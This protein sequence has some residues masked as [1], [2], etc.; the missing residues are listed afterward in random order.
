V[1]GDVCGK[2]PAAAAITALARYTVRAEALHA[3]KPSTVLAGL[4]EAL[5]HYYPDQF[6]TALFVVIDAFEQRVHLTV[7]SGGHLLPLRLRADGR[8][9]PIGESG[10]LLGML[11]SPV[12]T[13]SHE[14]LDPGDI[15]VLYTDGVTE[16]RHRGEFFG[17]QRL[18]AAVAAAASHGAQHIADAVVAAAVD[19]QH[20]DARDDI[21]VL[22]IKVP[23][24]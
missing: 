17:E 6:C 11:A 21:A 19:F 22:V 9:G 4:H 2:G 7:A 1:L 24:G 20:L 16:A 12:L 14:V 10:M 3:S 15:V 18:T 5:L 8:A 13:D 23:A